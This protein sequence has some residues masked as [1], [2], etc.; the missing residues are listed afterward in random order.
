M[1]KV[2]GYAGKEKGQKGNIDNKSFL[3]VAKNNSRILPGL[4]HAT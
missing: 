3:R 2:V 4:S 1:V